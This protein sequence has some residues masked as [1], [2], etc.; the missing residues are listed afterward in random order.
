MLQ[1]YSKDFKRLLKRLFP[2]GSFGRRMFKRLRARTG[3]Q[4]LSP[5]SRP[6]LPIDAELENFIQGVHESGARQI[7][8]IFASTKLREDEGQRSTNLALEFSRRGIPCIFV[9]WRWSP[10]DWVEQDRLDNGIF[11]IPVDVMTAWPEMV[12]RAIHCDE[13]IALFEFPHP[14]FFR[15]LAEAHAAG[16]I[17]I[18]DVV[19]DWKEFNKVGQADWY[20]RD[21]ERHF[22]HAVDAV[23]AVKKN[24]AERI[25]TLPREAIRIIPNG[26]VPG[27]EAIDDIRVLEHGEVTVGYFGYLASAWFDWDLIRS[28]A[29]LNPTW[30]FYLIGYGGEP[31]W[32][33]TNIEMLGRKPRT[34]LASYAANWDVAVIPFKDER[35][36]DG[37]D[38]IKT[39]EYLAMGLPVVVTGVHPPVGAEAFVRR[40]EGINAF[41]EAILEASKERRQVSVTRVRFSNASFWTRRADDF[42]DLLASGSQ[43]IAEKKAIFG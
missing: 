34:E 25:S 18:Y 13:K 37:A 35:L 38:P 19:D 20:D 28:T 10:D 36:A 7:M 6:V 23:T 26:L 15:V 5:G 42:L 8:V 11:Q 17:T 3:K 9:Y 39:Y 31:D 41:S 27:I 30:K 33:P 14:S 16:W 43:R 32:L 29:R 40:V 24:L 1:G 21:F 12:L 2:A 22:F 4:L